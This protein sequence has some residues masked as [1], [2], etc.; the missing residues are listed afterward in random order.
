LE[1]LRVGVVDVAPASR[2]SGQTIQEKERAMSNG[3]YIA[4][5]AA[6]A[7]VALAPSPTALHAAGEGDPPQL[8]DINEVV[9]YGIDADTHELLR[10]S[11]DTD[12]F[13]IIGVVKDLDGNIVTD[14]EGLAMIPDGPH[15]GLYG[16][17]NFYETR[18]SKLVW[19]NARNAN[20]RVCPVGIGHADKV[21]GLVAVQ[22]QT[23]YEWFLLGSHKNPDT[24]LITIDPATGTGTPLMSTSE[25]YHGLA[26]APNGTLYG[27]TRDPAELFTIDLETGDEERVGE[28]GGYT[29]CE[30]LEHAFGDSEPRIKVPLEGHAVV[31]D[32]WTQDGILFGFDDDADAFLII[33]SHTGHA[34]QWVCSFQT[35][36]CEGLVF[37]T[38]Q[39]DPFGPIVASACD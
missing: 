8:T 7:I 14:V 9:L 15:K 2:T 21:E 13:A 33:D 12:E 39:R 22:D 34:V 26:L 29:K 17:A 32:S 16:T 30:A 6:G 31:P 1:S 37:T 38:Q 4:W 3:R 20:A 27:S 5:M 18:P 35:I 10:Y 24:G 23:T 19:I 11:F 28:I 25:R 36:D